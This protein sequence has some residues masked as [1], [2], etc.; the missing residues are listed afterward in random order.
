MQS[1]EWFRNR[2]SCT[3]RVVR[4]LVLDHCPEGRGVGKSAPVRD[5]QV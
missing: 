2:L 1:T 4:S 3:Q 5:G